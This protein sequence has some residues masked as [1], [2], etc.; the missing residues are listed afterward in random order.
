MSLDICFYKGVGLKCTGVEGGGA[1]VCAKI[2]IR[3]MKNQ[4][5]KC[6]SI[7]HI[8]ILKDVRMD[9]PTSIETRQYLCS[10]A[11]NDGMQQ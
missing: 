10:K 1:H 4:W 2:I 8:I 5:N 11:S 3:K 9:V 7:F 6:K